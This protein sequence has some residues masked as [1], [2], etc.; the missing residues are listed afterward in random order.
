MKYARIFLLHC[1]HVLQQRS[2]SFVWFLVIVF[3]VSLLLLF[4]IG[5]LKENKIEGLTIPSIT[6]YYLIG[7]VLGVLL[8]SHVEEDVAWE[9]I[10]EGKLTQYLLRPISYY[11]KKFFEETPHHV[12]QGAYAVGLLALFIFFFGRFFLV[13]TDIGILGLSMVILVIA[14]FLFFTYK[15]IIGI[16]AFWIVET[17]GFFE[18]QEMFVT[19][20]AGFIMPL[21][22]LPPNIAN[23]IY[24]TP[25]P[26]M[27]YFPIISFQGKLNYQELLGVIVVQIVWLV[28]LLIIYSLL[29]RKGLKKFS[30]VG[31]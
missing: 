6:S 31:Q 29:W 17:N 22:L 9:D 15:M 19:I 27:I 13:S 11:W 1:Q 5:A 20:L 14:Y 3:D 7:I 8:T 30:A 23:I 4:W 16:I 2:R 10:R 28:I 26:Y 12:L 18:F 21:S 25:F 24:L